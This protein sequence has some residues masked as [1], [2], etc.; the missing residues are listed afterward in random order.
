ME[1]DTNLFVIAPNNSG[2]TLLRNLIAANGCLSLPMEGQHAPGFAGPS[3]RGTRTRLIWASREE[4]IE[5]FS[6]PAKYDWG[7]SQAAWYAQATRPDEGRQRTKAVFVTSSPP[8]LLAVDQ[9]RKHFRNPRFVFLVRNPYAAIE[10]IIRRADQQPLGPDDDIVEVA[11]R[12]MLRCLREQAGNIDAHRDVSVSL[13]YEQ[14]CASPAAAARC[15]DGL[16]PEIG[17]LD[18]NR[19]V[20]VK[21]M[22]ASPIIDRNA[23]QIARLTRAQIAQ[24]ASVLEADRDLLTRF[25]Y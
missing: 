10:G 4:W 13:T 19:S 1:I 24:A 11:A 21:G 22:P 6:D 18:F 20:P 23:E 8:F 2:S 16:V 15:I 5:T 9:I 12:H 7:R 14:L 25:D 17:G 3:S